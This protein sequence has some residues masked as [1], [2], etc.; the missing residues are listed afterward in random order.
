PGHQARA[1]TQLHSCRQSQRSVL[2]FA[3]EFRNLA[4]LS[5]FNEPAKIHLFYIGLDTSLI[6]RLA[7]EPLP[8]TLDQL[9]DQVIELE[10]RINAR[11]AYLP[12]RSVPF[13]NWSTPAPPVF[14]RPAMPA[15]DHQASEPMDV[16]AVTSRPRAPLDTA[17][18]QRR[19]A[20][21]LCLYCCQPNH[22]LRVII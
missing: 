21:N 16:D 18:R 1:I 10:N 6:Q 2:E 15:P 14:P 19:L 3:T 8:N 9:I 22:I 4:S 20:N 5:G 12:K 13:R 11:S 17:E 7:T